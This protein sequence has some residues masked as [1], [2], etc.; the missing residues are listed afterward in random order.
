[1]RSLTLNLGAERVQRQNETRK[2]DEL[3]Q[4]SAYGPGD[5]DDV[6]V[7]LRLAQPMPVVAELVCAVIGRALGLPVP[8]PFVVAIPKGCLPHSTRLDH[9]QELTFAFASRD[10]GGET[11]AQLLREDS[12]HAQAILEQWTHLAPVAAFDEW[13]ANTDRNF[14]NILFVAQSLWLIDHAEGLGGSAR[15]LFSLGEIV[16]DRL[17]NHIGDVLASFSAKE[18]IRQL[19]IARQW[20]DERAATLSLLDAMHCASVDRW[21]TAEGQRELLDFVTQRLT[22]THALLCQ[23]LGQ[24][25][26]Q[27]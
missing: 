1:M 5:E 12:T 16:K 7:F 11:F 8:E 21:L 10:I 9:D 23:R 18:R 6:P 20:V 26:L 17:T 15:A 14:G 25:Q 27:L 4:G 24:P 22:A 3:W 2:P 19:K 13:M